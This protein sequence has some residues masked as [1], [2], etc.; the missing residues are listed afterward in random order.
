[1][2]PTYKS[3]IESSTITAESEVVYHLLQLS[4][5]RSIKEEVM[6]LGLDGTSAQS[7]AD[8]IVM[9]IKTEETSGSLPTLISPT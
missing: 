8:Q 2:D 3:S 1:M 7:E 9:E 5:K 4:K 6:D